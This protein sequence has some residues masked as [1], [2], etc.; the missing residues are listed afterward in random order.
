VAELTRYLPATYT[1]W[2]AGMRV[3][4]RRERPHPAAQLRLTDHDGW[5]ITVFATN[6]VGGRI[7]EAS[8]GTGSGP[9]PKTASAGSTTRRAQPSA[10]RVR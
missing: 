3:I 10:A 8:C 9:A 1:A 6:T 5:R 2:P 7:P 4:A